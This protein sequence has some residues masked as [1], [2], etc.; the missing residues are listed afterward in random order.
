MDSLVR[1]I[2]LLL[3]ATTLL[4]A[5]PSFAEDLIIGS[6]KTV[7]GEASVERQG[8]IHEARTGFKLQQGDTLRTAAGSSLGVIFRDDTVLSLGPKSAL[9]IDTFVFSP[10]EN[11]MAMVLRMLRGLAACVSGKMAKLAP[12]AVRVE[13]PVGTVGVRGTRFV[14][15]IEG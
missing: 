1:Q 4:F 2:V 5:G 7:E 13:T 10:G 11:K 12:G 14:V 8:E 6:V 15:R 3:M 9:T